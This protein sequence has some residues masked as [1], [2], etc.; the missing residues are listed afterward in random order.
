[1][2]GFLPIVSLALW[3]F[4]FLIGGF[5]LVRACFNLQAGENGI[6]ALTVGVCVEVAIT[7]ILAP[8]VSAP[9]LFFISA[10]LVFLLG[11]GAFILGKQTVRD[12][13]I[14]E[15]TP[16][17]TFV[18]IFLL[19]FLV[20]RGMAIFDDYA[21]L[22]TISLM[23]AGQ[24]PPPFAYD[25]SIPYAY[26][27]FLM[28]FA[29]EIMRI[30][31]VLPWTAFDLARAFSFTVAVLLA[32][33]WTIRMTRSRVAGVAASLFIAFGSGTRWLVFFLPTRFLEIL[34]E[35][36]TLIGSGANSGATFLEAILS[37]W[38]IEGASKLP[39]PFAFTNGIVQPGVLA[40]HGANGLMELAILFLLL[41][42]WDS[43]R[44]WKATI[45][46]AVILSSLSLVGESDLLLLLAGWV[47]LAFIEM[48]R[49]KSVK[50][51]RGLWAWGGMIAGGILLSLLQG[52][53][54]PAI[55]AD[56]LSPDARSYQ[57]VGFAFHWPPSI[58][59]SHLG[60][61]PLVQI[62][63]LILA[64]FEIG[65]VLLVLPLVVYYGIECIRTRRWFESVF[66]IGYLLTLGAILINFEGS[67]G[68][69]N[70]SRLYS[71]LVL[72]SIFFIPLLWRWMNA[73]RLWI[74][75]T[76]GSLASITVL[77]G[78][79]LLAVQLPSLQMS[80]ESTFLNELDAKI[81][82]SYWNKLDGTAMVFDSNPSRSVTV[83]GRPVQAGSTWYDLTDS[84][85]SLAANPDPFQLNQAGYEYVY[86]DEEY[87]AENGGRVQTIL[88]QPCVKPIESLKAWPG[89]VRKLFDISKCIR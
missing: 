44:D 85:K 40:M 55:V 53:A 67:T 63:T 33:V 6:A 46:I 76:L 75:T 49:Q 84:W 47:I 13:K 5:L 30:G 66:I 70:T 39:I 83:F 35:Q 9:V 78:L 51:D 8:L 57:T 7:A 77:G 60:V 41:L 37:N 16:W 1:M 80:V 29:A 15:F 31:G 21:H 19:S 50:L 27:Y 89:L 65:P 4:L 12:V 88:N 74:Q 61:L 23:A 38:R 18:P 25:P 17:L 42:L 72:C 62:R 54:F 22:P 10:G 59:S 58:V 68:V 45:L 52:G 34:S 43:R 3:L 36:V 14:S 2:T 28:L 32:G 20:C 26:H 56:W 11:V 79:V 64:L 69:R 82:D 87:W 86:V 71:F 24:I 81:M 73:K 48:I